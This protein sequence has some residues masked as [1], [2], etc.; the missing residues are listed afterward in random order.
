[1]RSLCASS[2][3][4]FER[5]RRSRRRATVARVLRENPRVDPARLNLAQSLADSFLRNARAP[6][7]RAADG[8]VCG[9]GA[10]LRKRRARPSR[11]HHRAPRARWPGRD[12]C[13]SQTACAPAPEE[14]RCGY[15]L[16]RPARRADA[17]SM[18]PRRRCGEPRVFRVRQSQ[19]SRRRSASSRVEHGERGE[20]QHR[21]G[22]CAAR[23]LDVDDALQ[24]QAGVATPPSRCVDKSVPVMR[25]IA[26]R[27]AARLE[28]L[29]HFGAHAFARQAVEPGAM[30]D[31]SRRAPARIRRR[32][33]QRRMKRKKRRMRR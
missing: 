5:G 27:R 14:R 23:G 16:R 26:L 15:L 13:A 3:A 18:A 8:A 33:R 1:M 22:R 12:R 20:P 21:V 28:Q 24:P 31:R 9:S 29:Q 10:S 17:A 11:R 30:L 2:R 7:A 19:L 32:L 25:S 6:S 4:S